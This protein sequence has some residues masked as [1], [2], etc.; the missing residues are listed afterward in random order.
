MSMSVSNVSPRYSDSWPASWIRDLPR[1]S[2]L[3]AEIWC[4]RQP[5]VD[6][7]HPSTSP[8]WFV[9]L[10]TLP[11]GFIAFGAPEGEPP[12]RLALPREILIR[13]QHFV[14]SLIPPQ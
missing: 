6:R 12:H 2:N 5:S 10:E 7:K 4:C 1:D 9:G 11:H 8:P 3:T 13:G 14:A